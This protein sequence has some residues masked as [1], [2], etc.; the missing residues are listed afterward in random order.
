MV[1]I[2]SETKLMKNAFLFT[3]EN[4]EFERKILWLIHIDK[5]TQI[6]NNHV[7]FSTY[8]YE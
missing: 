1:P 2:T 3:L 8:N 7:S 6:F 5:Q 4:K